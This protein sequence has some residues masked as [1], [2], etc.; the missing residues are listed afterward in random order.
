[1]RLAQEALNA[2]RVKLALLHPAYMQAAVLLVVVRQRVNAPL[3]RT[4]GRP[5]DRLGR[6]ARLAAIRVGEGLEQPLLFWTLGTPA[7][8]APTSSA[9]TCADYH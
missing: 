5:L 4:L 6:R 2:A 7:P 1:M 3:D 8:A 9:P